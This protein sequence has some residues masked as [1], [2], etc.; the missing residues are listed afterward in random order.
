MTTPARRC[1]R[2]WMRSSW[3]ARGGC[4]PRRLRP[5]LTADPDPNRSANISSG[6]RRRRCSAKNPRTDPSAG[7]C[8]H[9]AAASN[10]SRSTRLS[11]GTAFSLTHPGRRRESPGHRIAQQTPCEASL[12]PP[13]DHTR[14]RDTPAR[15]GTALTGATCS[16]Q[17]SWARPATQHRA[18]Q[19]VIDPSRGR[20]RPTNHP[21]PTATTL[22]MKLASSLNNR[23]T[24]EP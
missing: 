10:S 6:N 13:S 21:P 16:P 3:T 5:R 24:K 11:P 14:A 12:G 4:W 19:R 7:R 17:F 18:P 20:S 9:N 22:Q 2:R 8:P 15:S 23:G 1:G